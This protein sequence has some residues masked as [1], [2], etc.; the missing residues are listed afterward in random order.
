[1]RRWA[2]PGGGGGGGGGGQGH[3]RGKGGPDQAQKHPAGVWARGCARVRV[4]TM[5]GWRLHAQAGGG[6][7][8]HG[9]GLGTRGPGGDTGERAVLSSRVKPGQRALTAS[10]PCRA[11]RVARAQHDAHEHAHAKHTHTHAHTHTQST[12]STQARAKHARTRTPIDTSTRTPCA[13]EC[14]PSVICV[15]RQGPRA[16]LSQARSRNHSTRLI[17]SASPNGSRSAPATRA[18][19]RRAGSRSRRPAMSSWAG[20]ETLAGGNSTGRVSRVRYAACPPPRRA[21]ARAR[22]RV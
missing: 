8:G 13:N 9:C 16:H 18:P 3:L 6:L 15:R 5:I 10:G 14:S 2:G 4:C 17:G 11:A 12:Q 1:M 19:S 22:A 20:R 21:R 7:S